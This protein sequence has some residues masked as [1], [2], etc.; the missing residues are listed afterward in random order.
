[1]QRQPYPQFAKNRRDLIVNPNPMT[2][3]DILVKVGIKSIDDLNPAEKATYQQ[4]SAILENSTID[5]LKGTRDG[6]MRPK[7]I[8]NKTGCGKHGSPRV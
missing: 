3:N 7:S 1:M 6:R 2:I 5:D 8:S 4:W